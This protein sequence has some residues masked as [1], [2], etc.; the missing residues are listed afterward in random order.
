MT[1][2]KRLVIQG[3]KSFAP[4]TEIHFGQGINVIVGPNGSGKSNIS[5]ALCFVLGRLSIKSMRAAKASN[6]LFMGSK[7]TKPAKEASVELV[8]DNTN[9]TFSFEAPEVSLKRV[10]R[11]NGQSIY[12]IN[13]EVKTRAE[14]VETLAHAGIDPH[15]FN[16]VLQGQIQAIVKTHPEERRKI[17]EEVAGISIYEMRKEKSIKELDKTEERLK[18]ISTILRERTAFLRNLEKERSQ[19]L[20]YKELETTIKRCKASILSRRIQDKQKEVENIQKTILE[21]TAQRDKIKESIRQT[22]DSI[23]EMNENISKINKHIQRSTGLEQETLRTQISNLRAEIEGLKVRKENFE[24]RQQEIER[25]I[26]EMQKSIPENESEI[27]EL[28][29]ESPMVAKKQEEL[30]KKKEELKQIEEEKKQVYTLRTE[31]NA[32]KERIR[33][34][35]LNLERLSS[36]SDSIL[37]QIE[38]YSTD[39]EYETRES[40]EKE[41]SSLKKSVQDYKIKIEELVKLELEQNRKITSSETTIASSEKIKSQVQSIEVCPLCQNK[42]TPD[43]L[44]HVLSD[45]D[46]KIEESRKIISISEEEISKIFNSKKGFQEELQ[47][48]GMRQSKLENELHTHRIITDKKS[49]IKSLLEQEEKLKTEIKS[50]QVKRDNLQSHTLDTSRIDEKYGAKIMEIEEISARTTEDIDKTLMYKERELERMKEV[51]KLSKRDLGEM[52]QEVTEIAETIESKIETLEKKEEED[53]ELTAKFKKLFAERDKLQEIIQEKSYELSS[54]QTSAA[55]I[56]EQVNYLK[57]GNAKLS[58]ER[59]A[60][61]MELKEFSGIELIKS[62]LSFLDEKLKKSQEA[63]S[64]IGPTNM[65]ALEVYDGVKEEY[66]KVYEKVQTIENEKNEILR[67]IE[68]IDKKKK[69]SFMKTFNGISDLFSSNFSKLSSKGQAFLELEDKEDI[70]N[71]GVNIVVKLAKGKYFDVTSLSGGEQTLIAISLLFAIQEFRPYHFY[72]LDEIDAALDK[73]NSERL[74]A[75]LRKYMKDGQYI[76]ITHNDALIMDSDILYGVSMHEGVSKIL[77]LKL[78]E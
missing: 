52:E 47:K 32:V 71:G 8:F 64:T 20:R 60:I 74:S 70:F 69:K 35:E 4:K 21:K 7:Y 23:D 11:H 42:M 15:G 14:I 27:L 73:R 44:S 49:Q 59:E 72:V 48:L 67:I 2:I 53:A 51:I 40:C 75:L 17:V 6:L 31:L 78:S 18:E 62:P 9:K 66:D 10:V 41:I 57:V 54:S 16:L 38:E 3:F 26:E 76:V 34:K 28:R 29:K 45:S 19:A 12:K 13:D 30:K 61:E 46:S 77:S 55:Q 39:I 68:E 50:L 36:Q 5:D 56:E 43:H 25:R 33:D 24:H 63:I 22:Q 65:R 1:H 37:K 58:A